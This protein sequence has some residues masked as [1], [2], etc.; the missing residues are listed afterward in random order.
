MDK[1]EQIK[2]PITG[3]FETFKQKFDASLQSS[4][5]LLGEVIKFIKQRKG[6]LM[7][8]ILTLLMAKSCGRID[9]ATY[10]AAI[11]LELLHTASLV[12]DDVVD[13]S[14]K[15]R[16]QSS[17]N[18]IYDNKVSVLVGDYLLATS[19][20]NAAMTA[21]IQLVE[22][23]S[24]LGQNLS[25]G[26]IIQLSNT[27]AS[28]FSEDVYFDVIKKKTAALFSTA[29]EAG[30]RSVK[31]SDEMAEN[32]ALFG[33]LIGIAFQIKDDIFDYYA[34]DELG[35]P[36]GN[37]MKEGKLTLPSLYVLNTLKDESTMALAL[38]IRALEADDK[39]IAQFIEYVKANGGIEY[40]IQTM[41]DY[42]NKALEVLPQ[43]LPQELKDAL[44][45]YIDFVIER[46]K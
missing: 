18:A 46:K 25:E 17:V 8:P 12:H 24:R 32:A 23:V 1:L 5:P 14:D 45:A 35:K 13:E 31:C 44:T 22:L 43:T 19:L 40:A 27:N 21:N 16:G 2:K 36:T 11:S 29:A 26:E 9:D 3:E 20:T 6:K 33:E 37:D 4:N 39:E 34:S 10:H 28:D 15:R 38:K 41:T 7:R 42:R 30:V